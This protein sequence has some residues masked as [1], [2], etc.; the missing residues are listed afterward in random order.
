MVAL[1]CTLCLHSYTNVKVIRRKSDICGSDTNVGIEDL[2][3]LLF[4]FFSAS[5][6]EIHHSEGFVWDQR[7]GA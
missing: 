6:F 2:A 7:E 1:H 3:V 5:G 4:H